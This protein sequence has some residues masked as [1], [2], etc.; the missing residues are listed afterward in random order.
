MRKVIIP[1]KIVKTGPIL[2]KKDLNIYKVLEDI[3]NLEKS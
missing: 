1:G 3:S 2:R